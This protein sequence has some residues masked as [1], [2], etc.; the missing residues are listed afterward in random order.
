MYS[1]KYHRQNIYISIM[2]IGKTATCFP[3]LF[4]D[5]QG[6]LNTTFTHAL[7]SCTGHPQG[8]FVSSSAFKNKTLNYRMCL[9]STDILEDF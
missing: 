4:L 2:N 3:Q 8:E 5:I 6:S 9:E 7:Q 1:H